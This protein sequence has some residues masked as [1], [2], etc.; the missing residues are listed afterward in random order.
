MQKLSPS[1]EDYLEAAYSL[2]L[3]GG[4]IRASAVSRRLKVSK[5]SV[6]SAVKALAA[7]GLL[8]Q[9]RYGHI[10]LSPS[11]LKAGA[12]ITGR[13]RLLKDFFI[14]ILG[15]PD[16]KAEADACRAEH[17]LSACS[18]KRLAALSV[19]LKTPARARTLAAAK[20]AIR[21]GAPL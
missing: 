7:R 1:L 19:F 4:V 18:I 5:P 6:N 21:A 14:T 16:D 11:G 15:V 10:N 3:D 13:H 17:A 20:A 2:Q 12:E 8:T 9:E